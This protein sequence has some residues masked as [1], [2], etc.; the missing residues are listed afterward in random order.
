MSEIAQSR[1]FEELVGNLR[2]VIARSRLDAVRS[3]DSIQVEA[4]WNL[5]RYIVEFEPNGA[6]RAGYGR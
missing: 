3:V 5:G 6:E 2:S 4:C 1:G